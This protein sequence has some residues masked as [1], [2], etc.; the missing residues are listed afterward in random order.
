MA[1][2]AGNVIAMTEEEKKRLDD[3][4]GDVDKIPDI[5]EDMDLVS[6]NNSFERS[7][8][9]PGTMAALIHFL[10]SWGYEFG[11]VHLSGVHLHK[12]PYGLV[13]SMDPTFA[14]GFQYSWLG[15]SSSLIDVPFQ[16]LVQ[17]NPRSRSRFKVKCNCK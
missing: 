11:V 8:F 9:H 3:L 12:F 17:I 10:S 15:C 1:A 6:S 4:L 2:D 5:L 14:G 16:I 7:V 13:W